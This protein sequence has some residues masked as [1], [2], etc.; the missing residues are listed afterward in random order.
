MS[1]IFNFSYV[2]SHRCMHIYI[3]YDTYM[4]MYSYI[5]EICRGMQCNRT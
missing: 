3:E 4:Y 5:E 2:E 1:V